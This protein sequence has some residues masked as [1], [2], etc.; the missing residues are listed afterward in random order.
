M[1]EAAREQ[2]VA[3]SREGDKERW[4][5]D[6]VEEERTERGGVNVRGADAA[7]EL[8]GELANLHGGR[9]EWEPREGRR[10]VRRGGV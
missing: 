9:C 5:S 4:R 2:Q 10:G 6:G 3:A 7:S 1:S 8:A